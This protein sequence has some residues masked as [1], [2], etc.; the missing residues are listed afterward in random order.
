MGESSAAWPI[1]W[2]SGFLHLR[3]SWHPT[4]GRRREREPCT[5][6]VLKRSLGFD[7]RHQLTS[8]AGT[9]RARFQDLRSP[10]T[11]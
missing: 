10:G 9:V 6:V 3:F 11:R 4:A 7:T 2:A 5:A 8:G 1:L